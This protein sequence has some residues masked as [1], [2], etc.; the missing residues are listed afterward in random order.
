MA[1]PMSIMCF[2][3]NAAGLKLCETMS[4]YKAT[5][6]R[7]GIRGLFKSNCLAPDF[8]EDI[9]AMIDN[10]KPNLVV[11]STQNEDSKDTYFH[12]NFL[13][14]QMPEISYTLLKRDKLDD[15]GEINPNPKVKLPTGPQS[16]SALRISIYVRYELL[17]EF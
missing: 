10:K 14:N 11:M 3:W 2:S 13:P 16:G 4:Q 1:T 17:N 8:F 15:V 7:S 6:S 12:S 9:R 5:E